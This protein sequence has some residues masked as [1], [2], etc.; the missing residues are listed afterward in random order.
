MESDIG[1]S[2]TADTYEITAK[3]GSGNTFTIE[4]A[5]DGK[6]SMTCTK[7]G[8]GGCDENGKW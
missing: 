8:V 1:L 4:R 5:K 6:V 2:T 7:A 3:S